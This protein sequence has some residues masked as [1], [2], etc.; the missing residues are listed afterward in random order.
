MA[1]IIDTLKLARALHERG[2]FSQ[3]AA[4]ATAEALNDALGQDVATGPDIARLDGRI[5]TLDGRITALTW[6]VGINAAATVA[7]F[8]MLLTLSAKLGEIG[9]QLALLA[10]TAGH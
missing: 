6:A 3:D 4:A 7:I 5:T 2:G 8:G 1:I 9:G 10:R